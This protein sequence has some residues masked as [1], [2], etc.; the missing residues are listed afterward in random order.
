MADISVLG[1]SLLGGVTLGLAYFA[2]LWA[3]VRRLPAARRPALLALGSFAARLALAAA[4]FAL[5]LGGDARR[6][7]ATL[8]GF[9][10]VRLV[11]VRRTRPASVV[12]GGR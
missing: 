1:A 6:G 11:A 3:T 10:A 7:V 12:S 5:L 8:L 2:G 4:G 9:V